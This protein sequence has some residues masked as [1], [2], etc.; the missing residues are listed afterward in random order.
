MNILKLFEK[1]K[2]EQIGK[3]IPDFKAGDTLKVHTKIREGKN[4]RIQIYEGVC[5]GRKNN[6]MGSSF[7]VRKVS[8]N[9]G[10]ERNFPLYSPDIEKIEKVRAGKVR[11]SKLFYLR[12]LRGRKA[13]IVEDIAQTQKD[14]HTDSE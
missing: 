13:R 11:R 9:E 6:G 3:E 1:K 14:R 4:E 12:D 2:I 5:I 8:F 7:T 10:V